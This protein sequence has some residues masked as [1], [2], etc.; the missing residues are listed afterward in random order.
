MLRSLKEVFQATQTLSYRPDERR[1]HARGV[2]RYF[3][4]FEEI[5]RDMLSKKHPTSLQRAGTF[6]GISDR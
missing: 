3:H 5:L 1:Q 4:D 6:A 2:Y